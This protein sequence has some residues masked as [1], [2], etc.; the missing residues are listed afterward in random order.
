MTRDRVLAVLQRVAGQ[1]PSTV[2]D[3]GVC[4]VLCCSEER[5]SEVVVLLAGCPLVAYIRIGM[6]YIRWTWREGA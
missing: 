3:E 2:G 6:R 4:D 5:A 1:E